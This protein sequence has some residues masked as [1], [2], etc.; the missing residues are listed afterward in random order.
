MADQDL[1]LIL[2]HWQVRAVAWGL[3]LKTDVLSQGSMWWLGPDL[4][5]TGYSPK[6]SDSWMYMVAPQSVSS[7]RMQ[8][9]AHVH[10]RHHKM[11]PS[12]KLG[13]RVL[14]P[15][16]LLKFC[17]GDSKCYRYDPCGV[18]SWAELYI[19]LPAGQG[20]FISQRV[21]SIQYPLRTRGSWNLLNS[22]YKDYG[23]FL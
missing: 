21:L 16:D 1:C 23:K 15:L 20:C 7:T 22:P 11:C 19:H 4:C 8:H 2:L 6:L 9:V 17:G 18:S 5:L 12:W 3:E 10:K 14:C 13:T